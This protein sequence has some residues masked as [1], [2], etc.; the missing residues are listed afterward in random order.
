MTTN[1]TLDGQARRLDRKLA[2]TLAQSHPGGVGPT[3]TQMFEAELDRA[4]EKWWKARERART[5]ED[6]EAGAEEAQD[7]QIMARGVMRGVARGMAIFTGPRP[8]EDKMAY[9]KAVE[10]ASTKRV[11]DKLLPPW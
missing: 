3:M 2:A 5:L 11:E 1:R 10:R 8:A 4:T 7:D 9:L 6:G